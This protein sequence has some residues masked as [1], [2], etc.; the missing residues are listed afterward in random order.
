[1]FSNVYLKDRLTNSI[2]FRILNTQ[3]LPY[4]KGIEQAQ[5]IDTAV[6]SLFYQNGMQSVTKP[7]FPK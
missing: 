1:M 4:I 5:K 7:Y 3:S 6:G 2:L